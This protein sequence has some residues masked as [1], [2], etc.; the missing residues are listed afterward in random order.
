MVEDPLVVALERGAAAVLPELL[1]EPGRE[2]DRADA[3]LGLGVADA[4]DD[5]GEGD[6]APAEPDE[7]VTA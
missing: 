3:L 4:E 5:F 7:L 1:G 6:V 2:R